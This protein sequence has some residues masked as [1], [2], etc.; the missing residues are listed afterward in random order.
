[1]QFDGAVFDGTRRDGAV[2]R[3][4]ALLADAVGAADGLVFGGPVSSW[5]DDQYVLGGGQVET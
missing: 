1:M 5:V 2:H 3:R 4:E